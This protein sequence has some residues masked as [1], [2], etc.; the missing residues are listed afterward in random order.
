MTNGPEGGH[1]PTGEEQKT[2]DTQMESPT[3]KAATEFRASWRDGS[4][5]GPEVINEIDGLDQYNIQNRVEFSGNLEG[6]RIYVERDVKKDVEDGEWRCSG[7]VDG[8][9]LSREKA[10]ELFEFIAHVKQSV[11]RDDALA[12]EVKEEEKDVMLQE[13][14]QRA[15]AT[16]AEIF[17]TKTE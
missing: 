2:I 4:S 5:V 11:S 10:Q 7:E 9:R 13:E 17:G 15:E 1:V 6:H 14:N 16:L 8:N 12:K 3:K